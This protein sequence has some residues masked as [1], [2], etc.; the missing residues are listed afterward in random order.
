[1]TPSPTPLAA[2]LPEIGLG[3]ANMMS[4]GLPAFIDAAERADFHRITVSPYD[5]TVALQN[6]W[7]EA[8]LR[9]RIDTAGIEVTMID[10]L[11]SDLPGIHGPSSLDSAV[12][13]ALPQALLDAPDEA[14]GIR[15]AAVLGA[16]FVNVTHFMG[17]ATPTEELAAAVGGVC[18]RA[19]E[20]GLEVSLEFIPATGIP[21]LRTAQTIIEAC[22]ETNVGLLLDVFHHDASGGTVEDIRRLP[23]GAVA[24]V[25]LSDRI[26][27]APGTPHLQSMGRA[28]PG[29]GQLPLPELMAAALANN[30]D[31]TVDVEVLNQEI[32]PLPP[33]ELAACLSVAVRRWLDTL[34]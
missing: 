13:A 28:L 18:R 2:A 31:A 29:E 6:G 22:G 1:L 30:P 9:E 33:D 20:H 23:P 12:R 7:T 5:F 11:G 34:H 26:R 32:S 3:W 24:A 15:A 21:D 27:P 17:V 25:Q 8:A 19:G 4:A 14:T 10:Y 16:R